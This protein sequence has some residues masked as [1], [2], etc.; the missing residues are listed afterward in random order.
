MATSATGADITGLGQPPGSQ[1]AEGLVSSHGVW[2]PL[3]HMRPSHRGLCL[4]CPHPLP[5]TKLRPLSFEGLEAMKWE[6]RGQRG[7]D[8]KT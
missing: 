7:A 6:I 5:P 8:F 3:S 1:A 2:L 4:I